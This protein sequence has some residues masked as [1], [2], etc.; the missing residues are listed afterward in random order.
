MII[1]IY[2]KCTY[3]HLRLYNYVLFS[4]REK[5]LLCTAAKTLHRKFAINSFNTTTLRELFSELM[6]CCAAVDMCAIYA[7]STYMNFLAYTQTHGILLKRGFIYT[8]VIGQIVYMNRAFP[9]ITRRI[10]LKCYFINYSLML[11]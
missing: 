8:Y 9:Y 10:S 2:V 5:A 4:V 1:I 11:I 6:M 7:Y 3:F